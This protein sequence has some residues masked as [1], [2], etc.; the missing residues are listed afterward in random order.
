MALSGKA[1]KSHP[2]AVGHSLVKGGEA[3]GKETIVHCTSISGV[4]GFLGLHTDH[5]SVLTVR[6]VPERST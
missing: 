5:K 4:S 6:P 3:D 1:A 2:E